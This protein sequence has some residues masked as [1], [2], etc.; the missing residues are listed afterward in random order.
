M[1]S[2][3]M[4]GGRICLLSVLGVV[5]EQ[6]TRKPLTF[7]N[8]IHVNLRTSSFKMIVVFQILHARN[9]GETP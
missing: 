2:V 8:F 6:N 1:I 3:G 7:Y 4:Q 9:A 5:M